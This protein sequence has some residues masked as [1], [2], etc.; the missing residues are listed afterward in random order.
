MNTR[1]RSSTQPVAAFTLVELAI[2]LVII[3]LIIGGVLAGRDL[4]DASKRRAT[5]RQ[6]ETYKTAALTFYNKYNAIPGDIKNATNFWGTHCATAL[7]DPHTD[8]ATCNGNGDG[9]L[10]QAISGGSDNELFNFWHHLQNAGYITGP[11]YAGFR[12]NAT[13]LSTQGNHNVP[14]A[15]IGK[16]VVWS[17]ANVDQRFQTGY[18]APGVFSVASENFLEGSYGHALQ[19]SCASVNGCSYA[20]PGHGLTPLE[21]HDIDTK[22]DDGLAGSGNIVIREYSQIYG[23]RRNCGLKPDGTDAMKSTT[24]PMGELIYNT[25][26]TTTYSACDLVFKRAFP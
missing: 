9:L 25:S 8:T 1:T 3:G 15:A 11:I 20:V 2:V 26:P 6:F 5:I 17:V 23:L 19:L 21:A 10:G 16:G 4:I 12:A 7:T 14:N 13:A 22:L 24:E 18:V